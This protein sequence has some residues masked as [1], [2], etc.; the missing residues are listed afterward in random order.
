MR[1]WLLEIR[2]VSD[3]RLEKSLLCKI[4]GHKLEFAGAGGEGS[5]YEC[6]RER[7][8]MPEK[9]WLKEL[10]LAAERRWTSS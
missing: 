1:F 10:V 9:Y 2:R 6:V 7:S 3:R 5:V 8:P 4:F